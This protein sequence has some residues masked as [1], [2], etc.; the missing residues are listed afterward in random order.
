MAH[1]EYFDNQ[2]TA[3]AFAQLLP[4]NRFE[5]TDYGKDAK[6]YYIEYIDHPKYTR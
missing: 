5:V 2:H 6:G 1:R 3:W 4:K